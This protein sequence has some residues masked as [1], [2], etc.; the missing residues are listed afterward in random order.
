MKYK[1]DGYRSGAAFFLLLLIFF[2]FNR[3]FNIEIASKKKNR[4]G[5]LPRGFF[6]FF[7]FLLLKI[8]KRKSTGDYRVTDIIDWKREIKRRNRLPMNPRGAG[9]KKAAMFFFFIL[10]VPRG[11]F[12]VPPSPSAP[13]HGTPGRSSNF[14]ARTA[15]RD[16]RPPPFPT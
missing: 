6:S 2:T 5:C 13:A 4:V 8:L 7:F 11:F 16:R 14:V 12:A 10:F 1:P 3:N 9:R 15:R